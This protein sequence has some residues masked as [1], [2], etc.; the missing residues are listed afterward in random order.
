[1]PNV[2]VHDVFF[3]HI[4]HDNWSVSR[5]DAE[6]PHRAAH[7]LIVVKQWAWILGEAL[8]KAYQDT[9]KKIKQYVDRKQ[10]K[11][12]KMKKYNLNH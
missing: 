10:R 12:H 6:E 11:L 5:E 4:C 1:M 9:C 2:W 8:C 3:C 7:E